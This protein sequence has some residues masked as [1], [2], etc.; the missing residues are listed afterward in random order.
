MLLNPREY[1]DGLLHTAI[2]S[3]QLSSRGG[4]KSLEKILFLR[5]PVLF[6]KITTTRGN[7]SA[8]N[9][10]PE[11]AKQKIGDFTVKIWPVDH[12]IP[13]ASAFGIKTSEGWIIYTGDLRL[14]GKNAALTRRFFEEAAKLEPLALICEGTH[15]GKKKPVTEGEVAANCFEVVSKAGGLLWRISARG[16]SSACFRSSR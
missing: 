11:G 9:W 6:G 4:I 14:H 2:T 12:S 13:G 5:A 3:L 1:K 16:T 8:A 15:P 10:K 7:W